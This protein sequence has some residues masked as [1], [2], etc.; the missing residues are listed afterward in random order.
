MLL[1]FY[2]FPLETKKMN[3]YAEKEITLTI[4]YK[5]LL[6]Y[7]SVYELFKS[8]YNF[9]KMLKFKQHLDY[10]YCNCTPE[11]CHLCLFSDFI[12]QYNMQDSL[13]FYRNNEKKLLEIVQ[14]FQFY[15][16]KIKT[17]MKRYPVGYDVLAF[18]KNE[19]EWKYKNITMKLDEIITYDIEIFEESKK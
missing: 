3:V 17:A 12:I 19:Y 4:T 2:S 10:C 15:I 5:D 18:F 16:D 6:Q 11:K 7:D 9:C 8:L 14:M 13:L 1:F